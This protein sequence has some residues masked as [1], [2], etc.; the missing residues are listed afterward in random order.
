MPLFDTSDVKELGSVF[1]S[2]GDRCELT[3]SQWNWKL[4]GH[5][6]KVQRTW[7]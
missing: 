1:L 6:R 3:N 4:R 5:S 7:L 2:F